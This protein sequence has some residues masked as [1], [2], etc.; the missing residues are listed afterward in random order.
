MLGVQRL[1]W[2]SFDVLH[3]IIGVS[4]PVLAWSTILL[5]PCVVGKRVTWKITGKIHATLSLLLLLMVLIQV[6]Y[7]YLIMGG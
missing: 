6:L 7:G 5:S 4:I 2:A 3:L 1:H